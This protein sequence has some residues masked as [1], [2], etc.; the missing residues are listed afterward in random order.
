MNCQILHT[1]EN[2]IQELPLACA[3]GAKQNNSG[4]KIAWNSYKLNMDTNDIGLPISALVPPSL[5]MTTKLAM[6]LIK[7]NSW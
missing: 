2:A 6:P 7:L 5:C 1:A 3:R 4:Y